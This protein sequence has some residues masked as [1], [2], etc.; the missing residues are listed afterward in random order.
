MYFRY[1]SMYPE[2]QSVDR[3]ELAQS[4][5]WREIS[6]CNTS[7]RCVA[8]TFDVD[9]EPTTAA[10]ILDILRAYNVQCTFFVPGGFADSCPSLVKRMAD[11]GHEVASHSYSHPDF[12]SIS[13]ERRYSEITMADTAISRITG[14][15][16]KPYF[17]FPYGSRNSAILSQLN[18]LGYLSVYWDIDPSDY[19]GISADALYTRV[20]SQIHPG[21]IVIMHTFY[22]SQKANGL[23]AI[24]Q[25]LRAMGYEP[26]TIT[27]AL[28]P[29]D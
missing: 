22:A 1:H 23:P 18:S 13:A 10:V 21:A 8:L 16:P 11:E 29:D 20:M 24:I 15:S 28:L 3:I 19:T 12:A 27:E 14:Y 25:S 6:T 9:G 7:S 17:R 2:W 5:G 4:L 26:V